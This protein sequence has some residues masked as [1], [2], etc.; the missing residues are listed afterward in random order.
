[1]Q[2]SILSKTSHFKVC[3]I[4][5]FYCITVWNLL[6]EIQLTRKPVK[7]NSVFDRL[8]AEYFPKSYI[9]LA[10]FFFLTI[11]QTLDFR[12]LSPTFFKLMYAMSVSELKS[13]CGYFLQAI[14]WCPTPKLAVKLRR[15]LGISMINPLIHKPTLGKKTIDF[16]DFCEILVHLQNKSRN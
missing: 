12:L 2:N 4:K 1:M 13:F 10:K 15:I 3:I 14:W 5:I 6:S 11:F 7:R 9:R 8:T 16:D